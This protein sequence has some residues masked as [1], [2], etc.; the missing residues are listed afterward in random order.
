[1]INDVYQLITSLSSKV[2]STSAK[3]T[4][5]QAVEAAA[6]LSLTQL[7]MRR[8]LYPHEDDITPDDTM[9]VDLASS[10]RRMS[11]G[12]KKDRATQIRHALEG[13]VR[14]MLPEN[15]DNK[16]LEVLRGVA[17]SRFPE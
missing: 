11:V 8:S 15:S 1:M 7:L 6:L 16:L 9:D 17:V 14:G 5:Q 4:A 3:D 12:G 10:K 2:S 13:D